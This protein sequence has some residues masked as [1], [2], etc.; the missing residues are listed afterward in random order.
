MPH[1]PLPTHSAF[2]GNELLASGS[3]RDVALAV[4]RALSR[5]PHASVLVFSN[6]SGKQVELDLSGGTSAVEVRYAPTPAP[7]RTRGRPRRSSCR[8]AS[9]F[10]PK[11]GT[12]FPTSGGRYSPSSPRSA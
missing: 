1:Q 3:L 6:A 2:T 4:S 8:S 9:P 5:D 7:A 10:L 12:A 11:I